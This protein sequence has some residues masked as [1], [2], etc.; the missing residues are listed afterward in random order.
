MQFTKRKPPSAGEQR[1]AEAQAAKAEAS[2][3]MQRHQ[4]VMDRLDR[5]IRAVAPAEAAL[6]RFDAEQSAKLATWAADED[7]GAAPQPDWQLR[8]RL[9]RELSAARATAASAAGAKA[10]PLAAMNAAGQR[11]AAA[12]RA[13]WVAAKLVAIEE[14]EATLE[15]LK[16]AIAQI[17]EAKKQVDAVR[18]G[19]LAGLKPGDDTSEIFIALAAFDGKRRAAESVPMAELTPPTGIVPSAE[20]ALAAALQALGPVGNTWDVGAPPQANSRWV[21]PTRMGPL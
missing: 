11:A 3:E 2:A 6:A 13:A 20:H 12:Q 16:A 17:Y 7:A 18:E 8:E 14:A 19:I 21:N 10:V 5:Q 15:P 1:L 4:G 9:E